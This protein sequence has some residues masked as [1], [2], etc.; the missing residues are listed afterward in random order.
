M[1][2]FEERQKLKLDAA[3]DKPMHSH[4]ETM[5]LKDSK[6]WDT[7]TK[8]KSEGHA[9]KVVIQTFEC[10][11]CGLQDQKTKTLRSTIDPHIVSQ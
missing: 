1:L 7:S 11:V 4:E 10:H 6:T 9:S 2:S 5:R 8:A 3:M